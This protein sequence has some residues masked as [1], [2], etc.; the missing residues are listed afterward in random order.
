[1]IKLIKNMYKKYR[2]RK[3]LKQLNKPRKYIY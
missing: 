2:V 3:A 1:M